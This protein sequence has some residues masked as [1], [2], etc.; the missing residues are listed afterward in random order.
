MVVGVGEALGAADCVVGGISGGGS[1]AGEEVAWAGDGSLRE[2]T[3][4]AED[5]ASRAKQKSNEKNSVITTAAANLLIVTGVGNCI[6][7]VDGK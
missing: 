1:L 4:G 2:F 6:T 7:V 3:A 5:G